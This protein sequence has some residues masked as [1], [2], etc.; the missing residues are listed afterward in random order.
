MRAC[1]VDSVG[2]GIQMRRSGLR[3]DSQ[4]I[5]IS[6]CRSHGIGASEMIPIVQKTGP[7][8]VSG[9]RA[10]SVLVPTRSSRRFEKLRAF[11]KTS[12]S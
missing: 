3:D 1:R 2:I 12:D 7:S 6:S 9:D 11:T 10:E 8:C 4:T 5:G